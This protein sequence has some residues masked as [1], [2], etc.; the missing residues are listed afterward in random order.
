MT[1]HLRPMHLRRYLQDPERDGRFRLDWLAILS[2]RSPAA[3]RYALH[4]LHP[5]AEQRR[6]RSRPT[7]PKAELFRLIRR[8]AGKGMSIRALADRHGVGDRTVR[9]ALHSP[10]PKPR[11]QYPPRRSRLDPHKHAIDAMLDTQQTT[12]SQQL[13]SKNIHQRLLAEHGEI[14]ISESTIRAYVAHHRRTTPRP[15]LSPAHQ[16]IEDYDLARLRGLL[17]TG[18]DIDDDSGD[19]RTLLHHALDI[20]HARHIHA[21]QPPHADITTF[22]L[23]RGAN[24]QRQDTLGRPALHHARQLG[25]WLAVEIIQAWSQQPHGNPKTD[26]CQVH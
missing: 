22:L 24:P 5:T 3:L 20:E 13:T 1:N 18:H 25:H 26:L 19:G 9:Q 7:L 11:K 2:G 17:D 21:Q 8:D 10:Q 14:G 12:P 15:T 23:I 6:R 4:D 16:A